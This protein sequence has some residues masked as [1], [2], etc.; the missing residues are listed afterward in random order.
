M[1]GQSVEMQGILDILKEN[2][3]GMSVTDIAACTGINRNT[4]SRYLDMLRIS[5]QVEMKAYGKAKV[6]YLS[7][8]VPISAML[9][10]SSDLVIVLDRDMTIVQAN[11]AVCRF[12][13]TESD[14]IVG[15]YLRDS[16]LAAFDHPLI[17]SRIRESLDGSE[18]VEELRFLRAG[19]ELFFRFKIIPSVF[20]S[21]TPG[22]T[23]ILEDITAQ[24]HSEDALRQSEQKYRTIV[25][26]IN[27]LIWHIDEDG[28]CTYV[29]PRSENILG[30]LPGE[31]EGKA[32]I[33]LM[34][35]SEAAKLNRVVTGKTGPHEP[36]SF[37]ELTLRHRE[38]RPVILESSGSPIFDALGEYCGYR[39]ISRDITE[40]KDANRKV[41]RW[42]TF[43]YSIVENI[44]HLVIVREMEG[45]KL[46]FFNRSTEEALGRPREGMT[47]KDARELF[48]PDVAHTL[49]DGDEEVA[50][51]GMPV[52][53]MDASLTLR[54]GV[55]RL[56]CL[57]KLPLFSPAGELKYILTIGEDITER[58]RAEEALISERDLAR[59]YLEVAGVLIA[60]VLPDGTIGRI[61]QRGAGLLG[62]QSS[63]LIGEDWFAKLVPMT[64]RDRQ[65]ENFSAIVATSEAP[66]NG[67]EVQLVAKDGRPVR[68]ICYNTQLRD[69]RGNI[70]AI[71]C[72]GSPL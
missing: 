54:D 55:R 44:P 64:I 68:L 25:E 51:G 5:G 69:A 48:L 3:R 20:N 58:R 24:K 35:T 2:P 61:N 13:N 72:S 38:N 49:T 63:D 12:T 1:D 17:I 53:V 29:S 42:K 8:R 43:L 65:R 37:L 66:P 46:I 56:F 9:D 30:W 52:E 41:W 45:G 16:P 47:G 50:A 28:N 14:A 71:I 23:L 70:L 57:R 31:L 21:G 22:V 11:E 60:V 6:F 39:I 19:E 59:S 67:E 32:I 4:V 15:R 40:R 27:D 62:Y 7:R 34:D 10:L 26:E 18:A 33:T 36:F